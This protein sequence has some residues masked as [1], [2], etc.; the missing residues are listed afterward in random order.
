[1]SSRQ[2]RREASA[3]GGHVPEQAVAP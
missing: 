2:R 1:M 3:E